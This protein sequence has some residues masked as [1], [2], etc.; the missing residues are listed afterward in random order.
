MVKKKKF[1]PDE[2]LCKLVEAGSLSDFPVEYMKLLTPP[3]FVCIKCGRVA[4]AR[5]NLCEPRSL[6]RFFNDKVQGTSESQNVETIGWSWDYDQ[7]RNK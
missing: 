6:H 7:Y 2:T 3:K 5:K 4:R 1:N